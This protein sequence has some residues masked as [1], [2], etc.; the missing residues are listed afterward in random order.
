MRFC[1]VACITTGCGPSVTIDPGNGGSPST[2]SLGGSPEPVGGST[3][4]GGAPPTGGAGEG[5]D[6]FGGSLSC[7]EMVPAPAPFEQL[8][9]FTGSEDFVFD[10]LGNYVG[11]DG[12]GNLVRISIDGQQTLWAPAI[13]SGF[14]AG[15]GI[16]PDGAVIVCDAGE[17][18]LKKI[19]PNGTVTTLLGGL[20]YPNGMDIGADGFIYVA[21][22]NDDQ[23]RRVNPETGA[24]TIAAEGLLQPNG[25]TVSSDPKVFFVGSFGGG[26]VYKVEMG[27]DPTQPGTVS[28]LST[29]FQAGLLDGIG[30][31][32]CGY[33][34][35][36]EYTTGVIYRITPAG[37]TSVLANVPSAWIPNIKWGRGLGG[38]ARD[39]MYVA[40]RDQASL[41]A[42]KINREGATE[43]Y[44]VE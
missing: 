1:L 2:S 21:E 43:V 34:Y 42:I 25:V 33:V 40:D 16:L 20:Q 22:N 14:M 38:F 12:N 3:Q 17:G 28:E 37:D 30:V 11:V 6:N 10:E 18:S 39:V 36:A 19:L 23:V 29:D 8:F 7:D 31:D 5:G 4:V 26:V 24:F 44:D 15:M 9:G 32:E 41:F 27:E 13:G 35:V